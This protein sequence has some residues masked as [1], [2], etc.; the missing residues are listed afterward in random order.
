MVTTVTSFGRSGLYDWMVQRVT[1]VV[2]LA[3]TVYL[4]CFLLGNSSLSYQEWQEL[5]GQTWMRIFS[6][7]ALISLLA[8]AWVGLWS[9]T[10]D[11]IT[12]RMMGP[13]ATVLRFI[14][15]SACGLL[16]FVYL[17]WG[18]QILWGI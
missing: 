3:Y 15:Q 5:F 6:L 11:Y 12:N 9:V 17:V 8:H 10:T 1:A 13:M 4:V 14:V 16:A 18:V 2:L 7:A